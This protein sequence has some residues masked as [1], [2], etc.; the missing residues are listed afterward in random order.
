MLALPGAEEIV[1]FVETPNVLNSIRPC[2]LKM[3][4]RN[5]PQRRRLAALWGQREGLR[6]CRELDRAGVGQGHGRPELLSVSWGPP[7]CFE[8]WSLWGL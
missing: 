3:E 5:N 6:G 2:K 1:Y 8:K 4:S 7:G